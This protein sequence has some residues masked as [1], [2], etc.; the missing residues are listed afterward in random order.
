MKKKEKCHRRRVVRRHR[1]LYICGISVKKKF[2]VYFY[3]KTCR[4]L[5][6]IEKIP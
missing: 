3:K 4:L 6:K 2:I 5:Y 1:L